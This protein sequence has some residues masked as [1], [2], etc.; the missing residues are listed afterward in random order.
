MNLLL[1]KKKHLYFVRKTK[2]RKKDEQI[3]ER[4]SERMKERTHARFFFFNIF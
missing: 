2:R 3:D 4:I 1:K